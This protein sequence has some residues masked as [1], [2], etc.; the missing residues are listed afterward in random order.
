VFQSEV[1][2]IRAFIQEFPK[3]INEF[4]ISLVWGLSAKV[5]A[6]KVEKSK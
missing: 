2:S 3:E 6:I 1:E 4:E 5:I